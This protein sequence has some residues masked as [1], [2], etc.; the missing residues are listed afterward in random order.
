MKRDPIVEEV[1]KARSA[2]VQRYGG[3]VNALCDALAARRDAGVR[4]VAFA[5]KRLRGAAEAAPLGTARAA[6]VR[7]KREV[8]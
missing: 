6:A 7:R 3:D 8:A 4:Y 1:R 5:P 2:L